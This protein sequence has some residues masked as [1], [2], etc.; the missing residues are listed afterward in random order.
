M[1]INSRFFTTGI[2]AAILFGVL[3]YAIMLVYKKFTDRLWN[4]LSTYI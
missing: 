4:I 1:L 3:N 2:R